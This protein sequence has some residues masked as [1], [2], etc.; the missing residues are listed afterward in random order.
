VDPHEHTYSTVQDTSLKVQTRGS[1]HMRVELGV[2]ITCVCVCVCVCVLCF[3]QQTFVAVLYKIE[4]VGMMFAYSSKTDNA[5]C[6]K[7]GI[8]IP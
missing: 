6:T 1:V 7:F 8:I 3:S 2:H 5:I 4:E